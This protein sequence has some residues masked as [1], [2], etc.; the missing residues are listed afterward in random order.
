M[1]QL[2]SMIDSAIYAAHRHGLG[3][4]RL[5]LS[6]DRQAQLQRNSMPSP[7]AQRTITTYR[8]VPITTTMAGQS[9]R[10]ITA[11]GTAIMIDEVGER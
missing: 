6:E 1:E 3:A 7:S 11:S 9:D 10:L 4:A 5:Y 2:T 8:G